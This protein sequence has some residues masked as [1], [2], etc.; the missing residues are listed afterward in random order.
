MN[1]FEIS[2]NTSNIGRIGNWNNCLILAEGRNEKLI[3]FLMAGDFLKSNFESSI[4]KDKNSAK[5]LLVY[6]PIEILTAKDKIISRRSRYVN[7]FISSQAMLCHLLKYGIP[8]FGPLQ[9]NLLFSPYGRFPRFRDDV[10]GYYA[11]Q[12]FI[13]DFIADECEVVIT[14]KPHSSFN[15]M[16]NRTHN[17]LF[18]FKRLLG[19]FSFVSDVYRRVFGT[20]PPLWAK[21]RWGFINAS[22]YLLGYFRRY[23]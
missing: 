19:D 5:K 2:Q 9:A 23:A 8:F 20:E 21:V 11:D 10:D 6:A 15:H 18:I 14:Q 12:Y 7:K 3:M 4:P 16:F 17:S 1:N 13:V 22:R